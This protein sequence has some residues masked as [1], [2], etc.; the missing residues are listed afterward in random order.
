MLVL[1]T[2]KTLAMAIRSLKLK[3]QLIVKKEMCEVDEHNSF[4]FG[5]WFYKR[6]KGNAA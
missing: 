2:M 6:L 4:E 3:K 1:P 5:S